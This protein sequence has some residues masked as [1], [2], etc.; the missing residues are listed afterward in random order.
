MRQSPRAPQASNRKL[1]SMSPPE[2]VC[3]TSGW[4]WTAKIP[5]ARSSKAT[6]GTLS[7]LAVA[8]KPGGIRRTWSPWFIHTVSVPASPAKRPPGSSGESN[9]PSARPYS[10]RRSARSTAPPRTWAITCMP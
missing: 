10:R 3:E 2:T 7:V 8:R 5:R 1:R 6:M 4:N 9:D